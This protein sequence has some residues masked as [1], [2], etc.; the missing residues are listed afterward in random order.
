MKNTLFSGKRAA[1]LENIQ[2]TRSIMDKI[3]DSIQLE[4]SLK[5]RILLACSEALT[6]CVEHGN[7]KFFELIFEKNN[8]EW[9][10]QI[11][12]DGLA[13]DPQNSEQANSEAIF[14]FD[15]A[16]GGRGLY[17]IQSLCDSVLYDYIEQNQTTL[18]WQ[19]SRLSHQPKLL[20][21]DDDKTLLSIC[22]AYCHAD[23]EVTLANSANQ[24]L[25]LTQNGTFD[26][27][28]SDI[29]MPHMNGLELREKI[30]SQER[31]ATIPYIFMTGL[32]DDLTLERACYLNIDAIIK[33]PINKADLLNNLGRA[34][35]RSQ[36]LTQIFTDRINQK[37]TQTLA[38]K[39]PKTTQQWRL[40]FATRNTGSGGGDLVVFKTKPDHSTIVI[41]D[42]MGHD[43]TAKF[44]AFSYMG[45]LRSVINA[46]PDMTPPLIM[47]QIN[48]C[49]FDD[50]LLS[51]TTLTAL[52]VNLKDNGQLSISHA[53]HP[54]PVK[55][56]PNGLIEL[57]QNEIL[58]GLLPGHCFY[59]H[60][61]QVQAGERMAL[62]TDGLFESANS[63]EERI[64]LEKT[65][66]K[67]LQ[68]TLNE[69]IDRAIRKIMNEFDRLAGTPAKDD[70]LL[71]LLEPELT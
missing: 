62:F 71:I 16:E 43:E 46:N 12:D 59:E 23:Y 40:E 63:T 17:L 8:S 2:K 51:Q 21:I 24:A 54:Q 67:M 22:Q 6:N 28:I 42:I 44:F 68:T 45:Y 36:Q 34:L 49:A 29:N 60:H 9:R 25:E 47:Q 26:I 48:Q 39:L 31:H 57:S 7:A 14:E 27:I 70:V 35:S 50:E 52:A 65:I 10:I 19:R 55:I 33:K 15:E 53:G 18:I 13:F 32:E 64:L 1:T 38:P 66:F 56:T 3:I 20:L 69:P 4:E 37:I 5:N 61:E 11:N 30:L 41:A 58:P